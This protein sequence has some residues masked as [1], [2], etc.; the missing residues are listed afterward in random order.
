LQ[1]NFFKNI[2]QRNLNGEKKELIIKNNQFESHSEIERIDIK[3][4]ESIDIS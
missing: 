3:D 1:T 2:N 4:T